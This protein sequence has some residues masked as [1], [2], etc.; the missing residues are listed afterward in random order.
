MDGAVS[1]LPV[2][3]TRE[4][5]AAGFRKGG[6]TQVGSCIWKAGAIGGQC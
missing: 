1:S 2:P 6:H 4:H 5:C 3:V